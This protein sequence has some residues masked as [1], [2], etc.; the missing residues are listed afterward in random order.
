MYNITAIDLLS[1]DPPPVL[2]RTGEQLASDGLWWPLTAS[3]T[4]AMWWIRSGDAPVKRVID[5]TDLG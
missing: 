5:L 4:A 1:D 3:E 2:R